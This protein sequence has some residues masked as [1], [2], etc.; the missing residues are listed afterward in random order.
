M[1]GKVRDLEGHVWYVCNGRPIHDRGPK[2]HEHIVICAKNRAGATRLLRLWEQK[3]SN[4][5]PDGGQN[6]SA[7]SR[8]IDQYYSKGCWG[9]RMDQVTVEHGLWVQWKQS[10]LTNEKVI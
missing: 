4:L 6:E 2:Q 8:E 3:L 7:W 9:T 1:T 5:P 10:D